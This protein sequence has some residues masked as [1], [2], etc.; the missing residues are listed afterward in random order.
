MP[1]RAEP[2]GER[3]DR[4]RLRSR[5]WSGVQC[6]LLPRH[7]PR[8][9]WITGEGAIHMTTVKTFLMMASCGLVLL[10]AV[11]AQAMGLRDGRETNGKPMCFES[12]DVRLIDGQ[13]DLPFSGTL[14]AVLVPTDAERVSPLVGMLFDDQT[15]LLVDCLD[16]NDA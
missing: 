2:P 15:T 16:S 4:Q 9:A 14:S 13:R 1:P 6:A 10:G 7:P 8:D 12:S 5:V 11:A 3:W